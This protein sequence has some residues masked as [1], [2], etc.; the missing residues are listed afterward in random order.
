MG[1]RGHILDRLPLEFLLSCS[2]VTCRRGRHDRKGKK[3][4]EGEGEREKK[5]H[6]T[7]SKIGHN[8]LAVVAL[9]RRRSIGAGSATVFPRP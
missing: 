9:S 1:R 6:R 2:T 3:K 8:S 4:E 5:M 7:V